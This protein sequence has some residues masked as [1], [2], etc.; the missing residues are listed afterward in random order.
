MAVSNLL[1]YCRAVAF[2][3][4]RSGRDGPLACPL[5]DARGDQP[6]WAVSAD[7]GYL[8]YREGRTPLVEHVHVELERTVDSIGDTSSRCDN[9]DST[10][11]PAGPAVWAIRH[12]HCHDYCN[13]CRG[14]RTHV[15]AIMEADNW[16]GKAL[17][18]DERK[19][20]F[21]ALAR[22]S[23]LAWHLGVISQS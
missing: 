18:R 2:I 13:Y 19:F 5:V 1:R 6:N 22:L 21:G 3:R 20:S 8:R 7:A 17:I 4:H 10:G 11:F 15:L 14:T 23:G 9:T 12:R 16:P